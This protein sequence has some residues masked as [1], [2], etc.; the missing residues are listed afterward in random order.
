MMAAAPREMNMPSHPPAGPHELPIPAEDA[1]AET[2][3]DSHGF[4]VVGVGASAGGLEAFSEMLAELPS[5]PDV[6]F[7]FVI[8]MEP[9]HESHL[10]EIL[11]RVTPLPVRQVSEGMAVEVNHVYLI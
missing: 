4:P 11:T 8:H 2:A 10:A 3:P 9:H 1:S 6:A 7:L 5:R